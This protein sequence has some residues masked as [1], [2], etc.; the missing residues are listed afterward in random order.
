MPADKRLTARQRAEFR[1]RAPWPACRPA[2]RSACPASRRCE[3]TARPS[4][5]EIQ[6]DAGD[7]RAPGRPAARDDDAR[8]GARAHTAQAAAVAGGAA[9]GRRACATSRSTAPAGP[10]RARHYAPERAR[11]PAPAARL[12]PRRRLRHR[13]PRHARR[14][15]A[16]C[17]A[18]T[19]AC[20]CSSVDYRLAPEHPF[21]AAVEDARAALRWA[22]AHAAE[23][24]ADPARIARRRRQRRRQPRGRGRASSPR[25]TAARAG[26]PAADLPGHRLVERAPLARAV[27]RGLLAHRG[28]DGL[29][30]RQLHRRRGATARDPRV[31]PILLADDLSG[32]PP[33]LV[34]T[35]GF[36]PL[37]D[38]GEAY[39]RALREAGVPVVLRRFTGPD[40]RLR[41]H[42][43]RETAS[44]DAVVET[45]GALRAL[46]ATVTATA[47]PAS[48]RPDRPAGG[49]TPRARLSAAAQRMNRRLS[50]RA[51]DA[52]S[53]VTKFGPVGI[54]WPGRGRC[55]TA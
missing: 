21:P 11:R 49:P 25:A 12:L 6:L 33:A 53:R 10:L 19:P 3:S 8:R 17:S 45:A 44:H 48:D 16:G 27:R 37:R 42:D 32:L 40:P 23:L 47:D 46:L 14:P 30:P 36:D 39:A 50:S 26:V 2:R 54:A 29:V 24:G 15:R 4:S 34:V 55:R 20:T 22:F 43:R 41:Q 35:A 31:S 18:A 1:A 38:E 52:L 13:R 9:A 7:A 5:P 28:R 51:C